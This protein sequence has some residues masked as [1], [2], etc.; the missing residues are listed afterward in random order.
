MEVQQKRARRTRTLAAR[1][2]LP[3]LLPIGACTPARWPAGLQP[4]APSIR[5]P[6]LSVFHTG[7]KTVP[8]G[9]KARCWGGARR[10]FYF[11]QSLD[12]F[13]FHADKLA[14]NS[15]RSAALKARSQGVSTLHWPSRTLRRPWGA[16]DPPWLSQPQGHPGTGGLKFWSQK[17]PSQELNTSQ[18]GE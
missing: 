12:L 1:Q 16:G 5:D 18:N 7:K 13:P 3:T 17:Q 15:S 8:P 4:G 2:A 10:G 6:F 11:Q 9:R 14:Q